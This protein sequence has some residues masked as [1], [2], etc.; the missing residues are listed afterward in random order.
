M[1]YTKADLSNKTPEELINLVLNLQETLEETRNSL[2]FQE[3]RAR[4]L[5]WEK[6]GVELPEE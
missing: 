2:E 5:F 3:Q 1:K 4:K 6:H